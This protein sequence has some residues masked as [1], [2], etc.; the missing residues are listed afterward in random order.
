MLSF[1]DVSIQRI[2]HHLQVRLVVQEVSIADVDEKGPDIVLAD[3]VGVSLLDIEKVLI[4]NGLFVGAVA[5]PDIRLKLADR[6]VEI[7]QDIGLHH[8]AIDNIK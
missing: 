4:R 6:G 3:L 7:D 1:S 5:S 2:Q 8:L